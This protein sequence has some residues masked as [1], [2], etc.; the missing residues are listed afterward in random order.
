MQGSGKNL[1][2]A[3]ALTVAG[4]GAVYTAPAEARR[5]SVSI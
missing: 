2:L 1:L 5:V 4:V 3:A